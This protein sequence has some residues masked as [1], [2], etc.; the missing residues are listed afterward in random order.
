[1]GGP[2]TWPPS[3]SR[4]PRRRHGRPV[5]AAFAQEFDVEM[6]EIARFS[7]CKRRKTTLKL[8]DPSEKAFKKRIF[9]GGGGQLSPELRCLARQLGCRIRG[10]CTQLRQGRAAAAACEAS[11]SWVQRGLRRLVRTAPGLPSNPRA[12]RGHGATI[13]MARVKR[14]G[15]PSCTPNRISDRFRSIVVGHP[16]AS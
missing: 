3:R 8:T 4:K 11:V 16:P 14:T 12:I 2:R 13:R 10:T 6:F 7:G 15:L 9:S 5:H 1:M